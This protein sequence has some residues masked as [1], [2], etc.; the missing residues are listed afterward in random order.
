MGPGVQAAPCPG[1]LFRHYAPRAEALVVTGDSREQEAK[2]KNYLAAHPGRKVA[3]LATAENAPVYLQMLAARP[4]G[5]RPETAPVHVEVLG[6][7][8]QPDEIARRIFSA[9]RRCDQAGAQAIL[10]EAIPISG[11][12]LAVMN[13][14]YRAAANRTI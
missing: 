12:G 8:S 7:R 11:I 2:V 10:M 9:L 5:G 6:S 13:R 14:L 1:I 3:L 4:D